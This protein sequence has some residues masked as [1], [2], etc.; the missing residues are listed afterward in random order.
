MM[1]TLC[2]IDRLQTNFKYQKWVNAWWSYYLQSALPVDTDSFKTSSGRLEKVTT[3]Y[4][5]TRRCHDVWK[6]T[7]DLWHLEDVWFTSLKDI[8]IVTSWRCLIY[9]L[10]K[11]SSL[12]RLEDVWFTTSRRRLI[13]SALKTSNLRR[14]ENVWFKTSWRRL[15]YDVFKTSVKQRLCSNVVVM[16]I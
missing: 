2:C 5:Q 7:S 6:K 1:I 16:S 14:L 3:S 8:Q 15:I 12:W 10:L 4:D 9:V 13:Y 11:T